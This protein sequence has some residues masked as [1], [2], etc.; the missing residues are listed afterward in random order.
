MRKTKGEA[1]ELMVGQLLAQVT[2]MMGHHLRTHM[3][4][5]GL[6]RGQGFALVH[7]WHHD[8]VPQR[9]ISRAMHLRPASVTNML[10]RMERN[11]W[12]TRSRDEHD[13][14]IVRVYL[15]AKAKDVRKEARLVFRRMED[16]LSCVYT[17]EEMATLRQLLLKLHRHLAE[18]APGGGCAGPFCEEEE[19]EST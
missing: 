11:G 10:Q 1:R 5:L 18:G 9:E 4:K 14:R 16:E 3:E 7:L 15:T 8:G 13:Q 6:H 17:K 19:T 12:I 2:R